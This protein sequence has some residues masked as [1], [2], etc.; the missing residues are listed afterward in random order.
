MVE[1]LSGS[2]TCSIIY[3]HV[4]SLCM[5]SLSAL[6]ESH[7]ATELICN[8]VLKSE[9][10]YFEQ[11]PIDQSIKRASAML[12]AIS[13]H[14]KKCTPIRRSNNNLANP[15]VKPDKVTSKNIKSPTHRHS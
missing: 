1:I 6:G 4:N 13:V 11:N 12:T 14:G 10:P 7:D 3:F 8:W 5:L 2:L 9:K 15:E